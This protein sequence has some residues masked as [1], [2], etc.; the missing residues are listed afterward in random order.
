MEDGK[1]EKTTSDVGTR[2]IV[3]CDRWQDGLRPRVNVDGADKL[4]ILNYDAG[5]AKVDVFTVLRFDGL[6]G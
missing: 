2:T 3:S 1:S 4:R 5:F 6:T